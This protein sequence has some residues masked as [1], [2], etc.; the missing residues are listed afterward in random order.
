MSTVPLLIAIAVATAVPLIVLYIIFTLDLYGTGDFKNIALCFVWG[1]LMVGVAYV[2]NT[3]LY[4]RIGDYDTMVRF[5]A[6]VVE[7]ILKAAVLLYLV[8]RENF[9]YFVDGAIYGFAVGVGFAVFE[10][11]FYLYLDEAEAL[12][13]A[14][15]R[16]L[17]TNLMHATASAVVGSALGFARFQR[18]QGRAFL[19]LAG[20][21][22]AV[23]FHIGFNNITQS[24][25]GQNLLLVYAAVIGF[26]GTGFIAWIIRRGLNEQ[27]QWIQDSLAKIDRRVITRNEAAAVDHLADAQSVLEPLVEVY[28][29]ETAYKM[30]KFLVLQAQ[31]GIKL[32][33]IEKLN[34]E[35]MRAASEREVESMKAEMEALRKQ[36]GSHTMLSLRA[37]FPDATSLIKTKLETVTQTRQKGSSSLFSDLARKTTHP[38]SPT[39]DNE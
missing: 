23:L 12:S 17:S 3:D 1:G 32:K 30:E 18:F 39:A 10:N 6:P 35:R 21:A 16:V 20:L 38:P 33:S 22:T 14:I 19:L 24:D 8:R 29:Q 15:G 36:I 5:V 25:L 27:K 37:I 11:Y 34:D 4:D 26:G 9:T 13:T 7:E 31:I 2:A 28:G